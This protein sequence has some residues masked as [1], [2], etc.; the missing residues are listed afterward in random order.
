MVK[1]SLINY[2]LVS[3][4]GVAALLISVECAAVEVIR[5]ED[6]SLLWEINA[7]E[8]RSVREVLE[9]KVIN[10]YNEPSN[11]EEIIF[12]QE[13]L[14]P[15]K[16]PGLGA[17]RVPDEVN[18]KAEEL[19]DPDII[20]V[21]P[22]TPRSVMYLIG[23]ERKAYE[24]S[25]KEWYNPDF[26]VL[27]GKDPEIKDEAR[28]ALINGYKNRIS[29][30][31]DSRKDKLNMEMSMLDKGNSYDSAAYLS[32]SFEAIEQCYDAVG[33]DILYNLYG[34]DDEAMEDFEKKI[35]DFHVS[36]TKPG[37]KTKYCGETC[38]MRSIAEWQLDEFAEYRTYLAELINKAPDKPKVKEVAIEEPAPVVDDEVW[39]DEDED[40][41]AN[42]DTE[43][44]EADSDTFIYHD[45]KR[46]PI[47]VRQVEAPRV[48]PVIMYDEDGV[49][50][51]DESEF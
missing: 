27:N 18:E 31:M 17:I 25:R 5:P 10:P 49:P 2:R 1:K 28:E 16:A 6:E 41:G 46:G 13:P 38:S 3:F 14:K 51:I 43:F 30:C 20:K 33:M 21:N 26:S 4:F 9:E 45:P 12:I 39:F 15:V 47:R 50:L 19:D 11:V 32:Q 42:A 36:A 44:N 8:D 29:D 34:D 24:A 23:K 40:V 48:Q 22:K 7:P 35:A 37:I